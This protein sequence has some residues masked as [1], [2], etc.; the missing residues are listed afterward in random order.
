MKCCLQHFI[1]STGDSAM[2]AL[3]RRM[4]EDMRIRNLAPNT[5]RVYLQYV[6]AFAKHFGRSPDQL[7]PEQVRE[8]LLHL[9]DARALSAPTICVVG[10]A[11]RF[12]Y[13][14]TLRRDWTF[15]D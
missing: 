7:E 2:T 9:S 8:F 5:Q 10:A 14:V 11:L 3:R 15:D 4:L 13:R 12:L 6:S 1:D